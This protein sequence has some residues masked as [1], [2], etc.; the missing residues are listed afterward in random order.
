MKM[1]EVRSIQNKTSEM[2]NYI[3]SSIL[4]IEQYVSRGLRFLG[5]TSTCCMAESTSGSLQNHMLHMQPSTNPTTQGYSQPP[6]CNSLDS[7]EI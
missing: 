4:W 3:N 2:T 1:H 6:N 7:H 5:L